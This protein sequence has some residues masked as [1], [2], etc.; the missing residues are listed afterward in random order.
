MFLGCN[1]I[2]KKA[3]ESLKKSMFFSSH[4][5]VPSRANETQW[6]PHTDTGRQNALIPALPLPSP[7]PASPPLPRPP[8][9]RGAV[10]ARP[11]PKTPDCVISRRSGDP[12]RDRPFILSHV[13]TVPR[14]RESPRRPNTAKNYRGRRRRSDATPRRGLEA[15]ALRGVPVHLAAPRLR[16]RG[17]PRGRPTG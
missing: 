9:P 7:P 11:A 17:G 2:L 14:P 1:F 10:V 8:S 4:A 16:R 12:P 15:R 13:L 6:G 3:R 5:W